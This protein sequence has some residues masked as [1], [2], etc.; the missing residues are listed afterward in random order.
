MEGQGPDVGAGTAVSGIPGHR[1]ADPV[2]ADNQFGA[3][4][5]PALLPR[6]ARLVRQPAQ[7]RLDAA[8][9]DPALLRIAGV[10]AGRFQGGHRLIGVR[11]SRRP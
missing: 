2:R 4:V 1:D 5:L 6:V 3:A 8:P 7:H 10:I 11:L 9:P